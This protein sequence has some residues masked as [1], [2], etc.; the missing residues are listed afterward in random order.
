MYLLFTPFVNF[1]LTQTWRSFLHWATNYKKMI[2]VAAAMQ[3]PAVPLSFEALNFFPNS[4]F[5]LDLSVDKITQNVC[6]AMAA[7]LQTHPIEY[8]ESLN[9][10]VTRF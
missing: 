4:G 9:K 2:F 1:A 6:I 7:V 8:C 3:L 5:I 10:G